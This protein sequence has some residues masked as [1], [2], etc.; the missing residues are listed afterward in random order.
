MA[1]ERIQRRLAAIVSDSFNASLRLSYA[2][3]NLGHRAIVRKEF[4]T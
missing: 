1:E 4:A 2:L 3:A